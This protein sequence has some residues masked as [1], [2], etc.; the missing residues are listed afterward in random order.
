MSVPA[1]LTTSQSAVKQ[2]GSNA[3]TYSPPT[4]APVPPE[5]HKAKRQQGIV[6]LMDHNLT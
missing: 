1:P 4:R 2:A 3:L 6:N 5:E